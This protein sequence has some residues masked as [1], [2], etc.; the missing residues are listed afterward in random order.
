MTENKPAVGIVYGSP[1]DQ[2]LVAACGRVL[3]HFDVPYDAVC[4]H[5]CVLA[6]TRQVKHGVH[7][8]DIAKALIDRGF[9]PPTVYF[10]QVVP[11]AL[12]IEPTETESKETLDLFADAMTEISELVKTDPDAIRAAPTSTAVSRLDIVAADRNMDLGV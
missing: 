4:M 9:H 7:A 2:E 5:E 6:A 10:P 12:M 8:M 11:E 3:E 1:T